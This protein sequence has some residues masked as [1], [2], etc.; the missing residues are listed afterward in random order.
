MYLFIY[1]DSVQLC[2]SSEVLEDFGFLLFA[3]LS[4]GLFSASAAFI[5][6]RTAGA[7]HLYSVSFDFQSPLGEVAI[8]TWTHLRTVQFFPSMFSSF[9]QQLGSTHPGQMTPAV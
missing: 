2:L 7:P 1:F 4:E 6:C 5:T 3:V 8:L 9:H